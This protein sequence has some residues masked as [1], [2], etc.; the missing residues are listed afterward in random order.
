VDGA[1]VLAV[2]AAA[3][4]A[5]SVGVVVSPPA[6]VAL[7]G[8]VALLA[9]VARAGVVGIT[10]VLVAALPIMIVTFELLPRLL[11]TFTAAAA[12]AGLAATLAPRANASRWSFVLRLGIVLFLVPIGLSLVRRGTGEQLIQAAKYLVFPAL[13][14][15]ITEATRLDVAPRL[16]AVALASSMAAISVNL[17]LGLTG[18]AT[19]SYYDAGEIIGFGSEHGLALLA[20][21]ATAA[22][23]V[24]RPTL[25]R[26]PLTAVGAIAT[27]A[28]GVRSV[29][30][31]L[32]MLVLAA[33]TRAGARMRTVVLVGL[34]IGAVFVSGAADVVESRFS[35]SE[36]RGEFASLAD[37]GSGRGDI[38]STAIDAW[39][40]AP[41]YD[42]VV[43]TGLRTIPEFSQ[44]RLGD[45]FVGH[46]DVVEVGVELGVMGLLGL[47]LIWAALIA[48]APSRLPLLVLVP[49]AVFNG[50]LEYQPDLVI[51]LV[52]CLAPAAAARGSART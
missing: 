17:V 34:A 49:F 38:Y 29:L 14:L 16:R 3:S 47:V 27:V 32:G 23:L 6:A 28:T 37:A 22:T 50:S 21:C 15:V 42:W 25:R 52:L 11:G 43:G 9:I 51:A 45:T 8:A 31:G 36:R 5:V 30:P 46:S 41:A 48:R 40:A 18:V 1:R 20:G 19:L 26:A 2:A 13:V 4:L 12:V 24:G 39:V 33:M 10:M 44:E 35:A 7:T